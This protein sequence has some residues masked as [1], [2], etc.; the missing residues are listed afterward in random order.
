MLFVQL[1]QDRAVLPPL[2]ALLLNSLANAVLQVPSLRICTHASS[3]LT[4]SS[5]LL[6][7]LKPSSQTHFVVS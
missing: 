5:L 7:S 3:R 2:F 4:I 1:K 6:T